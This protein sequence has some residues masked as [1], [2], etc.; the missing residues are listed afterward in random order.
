MIL[1]LLQ[2]LKK[3]PS[4]IEEKYKNCFALKEEIFIK[5]GRKKV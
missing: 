3:K 1:G 5:L 4:L 2:I